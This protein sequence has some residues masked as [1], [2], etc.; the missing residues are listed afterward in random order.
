MLSNT[1][2]S[3]SKN[4]IT[5]IVSLGLAL[6]GAEVVVRIVDP[7][8]PPD[9]VEFMVDQ[10]AYWRVAPNQRDPRPPA[11]SVN[12]Q[13]FRGDHDI[14]DKQPGRAR[15]LVLGDSYTWGMGVGDD[16]T[17]SAQLEAMSDGRLEVINGG[18]P[19]WGLFQFKV[20][21]DRWID[22]LD[23]DFV[24]VLINTADILRQPYASKEAEAEY[25]RQSALRN[26]IRNISKLV[27]VT[28]RLY[29]KLQLQHQNRQVANAVAMD[30]AGSVRPELF[31]KLLERDVARLREMKALSDEHGARFVLAAWPQRVPMTPAFMKAMQTFA[32]T[33]GAIYVDM[34]DTLAHHQ[35]DEYSLPNDHHPNPFGHELLA[36]ELT[37]ALNPLL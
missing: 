17:Y 34:S 33:S 35:F 25:L 2:R 37:R 15:V 24:V 22:K 8:R 14:G 18:T 1:A 7:V 26:R 13:G 31:D 12:R 32:E 21:L 36:I 5:A 4:A 20:R 30:S 28:Y 27:T 29:E 23:P 3:F 10:E 16:E 6:I 9:R 11:V 19:G